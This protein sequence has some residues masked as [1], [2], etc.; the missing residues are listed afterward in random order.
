[1]NYIALHF[2]VVDGSMSKNIAMEVLVAELGSLGFESFTETDEGI[3][4][5]IQKQDWKKE[6]LESVQILQSDEVNFE[7]VIEEIEQVNWNEE[8]EKNFEPIQVEEKVSI[9][10][11]FHDNPGLD[12]DI[13]IEPKMSFGTGHHETTHLMIEHLLELDLTEKTVLDMGCGTGILAIFAEMRGARSVDA[14]DIDPWCYE[15]S[16]E[17]VVRNNCARIRVF[18]GDVRLLNEQEYDLIIANINRNILL[19][20]MSGYVNCLNEGGVLLLSG[21]YSEDIDK[22]DSCALN[23]GLKLVNKK[24]RNNWVGLKYVN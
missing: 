6:L 8:W 17:N 7:F 3:S 11:P 4:G 9:R 21:F 20:D 12:Y 13:V 19:S 5:Y 2:K 15:N 24:E 10:A 14:I 23:L 16:V 1:M 22:I 18:E